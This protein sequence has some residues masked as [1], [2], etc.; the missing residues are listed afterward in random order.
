MKIWVAVAIALTTLTAPVMNFAE[1]GVNS[2]VSTENY[3]PIAAKEA[4]NRSQGAIQVNVPLRDGSFRTSYASGFLVSED[5]LVV[6][7]GHVAPEEVDVLN[8]AGR[9]TFNGLPV[10]IDTLVTGADVMLL[11]LKEIPKDM[12]PAV[13]AKEVPLYTDVYAEFSGEI[14]L[15]NVIRSYSG[16][17]FRAKYVHAVPE[18]VVHSF[19][20]VIPT[21]NTLLYLDRELKMGFSGGMAVN[22]KGEIIGMISRIDGGY[23]VL[24]S[25]DMIQRVIEHSREVDVERKKKME[26]KGNQSPSSEKSEKQKQN[27]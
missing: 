11:K 10:E 18:L 26:E 24:V 13:F 16:L 14:R 12:K 5:G 3:M 15:G 27:S 25:S 8:Q 1:E 20:F 19:G 7:A 9:I 22:S 23:T 2:N 21:G 17:A 4:I 6:T